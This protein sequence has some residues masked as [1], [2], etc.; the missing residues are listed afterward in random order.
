MRS[1]YASG[2]RVFHDKFGYGTIA[3]VEGNKLTIDFE[4]SGRKHV[5]DSFVERH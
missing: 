4:K 3:A 2:E 5:V 1:T